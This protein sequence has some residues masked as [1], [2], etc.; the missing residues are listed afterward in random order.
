MARLNT[1][2]G[3]VAIMIDGQEI[4]Y[5][6][7]QLK[8]DEIRFPDIVGRYKISVQ[9]EPDGK[10]HTLACILPEAVDYHRGPESGERLECQGFYSK[11]RVKLSIGL[12]CEAGY[13]PD[14]TR[15]SNAYDYDA[16]YLENGMAYLI[17]KHTKSNKYVFGVAW[18]DNVG[19]EDE[20]DNEN[21]RDVQTWFAADPTIM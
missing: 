19:G 14:G 2:F 4:E 16:D 3:Y 8:V 21:D 5:C 11:D 10:A 18:I 7:E 1:P 15:W 12:E 20:I 13:L 6:A 9:C 17:E